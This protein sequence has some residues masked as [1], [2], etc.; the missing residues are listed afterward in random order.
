MCGKETSGLDA[1]EPD[2]YQGRTFVLTPLERT[3]AEG[4]SL[5]TGLVEAVGGRPLLLDAERHDR[6]V[7]VISHLPY[8]LACGLVGTS[9]RASQGEDALWTLAASGFRDTSRLAASDVTM[10]LDILLTNREMVLEALGTYQECLFHLA[11]LVRKSE[12]EDLR[13]ML[14]R[15]CERRKGM[16]V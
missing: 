14:T 10:M 13:T 3:S 1:A 15:F 7:A 9:E 5:A 11:D 8:L 2:L 6:L 12:T 16:F 4:L